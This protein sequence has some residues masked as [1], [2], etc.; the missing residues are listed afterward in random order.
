M[1]HYEE[2]RALLVKN[3]EARERRNKWRAVRA[4]LVKNMPELKDIPPHTLIDALAIAG[5]YDRAWRKVTE[6]YPALR[7]KDY[8]LKEK[9]VAAKQQELG[10]R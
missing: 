9:L 10:Y 1:N 4:C 6:E 3:E 8:F 7:G 2:I 5:S